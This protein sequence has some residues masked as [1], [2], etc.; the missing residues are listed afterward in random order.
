MRLTWPDHHAAFDTTSGT[1][2][3][4]AALDDTQGSGEI[5]WVRFYVDGQ[6]H[7]G[8]VD[9]IYRFG[10][11]GASPSGG[12]PSE[13]Q[14]YALARIRHEDSGGTWYENLDTR[15]AAPGGNGQVIKFAWANLKV[16]S[17]KWLNTPCDVYDSWNQVNRPNANNPYHWRKLSDTAPEEGF[18]PAVYIKGSAPQLEIKLRPTIGGGMP[19]RADA[20]ID[21]PGNANYPYWGVT[22]AFGGDTGTVSCPALDNVVDA[23]TAHYG[24]EVWISLAF[25]VQFSDG[26][27]STQY[28]T[29]PEEFEAP[30]YAVYAQPQF[31]QAT[32]WIGVLDDSCS[33]AAG[34]STALDVARYETT[35]L[36]FSQTFLYPSNTGSWWTNDVTGKFQLPEFF[37]PAVIASRGWDGFRYGNCVDVSDYLSICARAVGLA[38]MIAK[39]RNDPSGTSQ[40]GTFQYN[41]VCLIGSDPAVDGNYTANTWGWHQIA[42]YSNVYDSCAAHKLD[43][44]G[45]SYRNP[46]FNWLLDPFWQTSPGLGI[47]DYPNVGSNPSSPELLFG[48]VAPEIT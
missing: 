35:G 28:P 15:D 21:I 7:E 14:V 1:L 22:P 37:D 9:Q 19:I 24:A 33:W 18:Y 42:I 38:F 26:I 30:L 46:P 31:P 20:Y 36:F 47:V 10:V 27:W 25:Q 11:Y 32:P 45:A 12:N 44:N 5:E 34:K 4:L 43:L 41:P 2:Y 39:Y 16:Q 23:Y 29:L 40:S 6:M 3:I 48:P 17:L 13:H 8:A